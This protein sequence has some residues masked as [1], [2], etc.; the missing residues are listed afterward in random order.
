MKHVLSSV[1][2]YFSGKK[3]VTIRDIA[4]QVMTDV[5]SDYSDWYEEKGLYLPPDFATDPAGWTEALHK[6]KR[7]FTLLDDEAHQEGELWEAKNRW[8]EYGEQDAERIKEL[9]HEIQEGLLLFG[10]N[11][12]YMTDPKKLHPDSVGR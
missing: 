2:A 10:Q 5:I 9:E 6:I 3:Q 1:R 11:L 8:K 4:V 7:A 12:Q